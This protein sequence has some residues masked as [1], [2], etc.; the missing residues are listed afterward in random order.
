MISVVVLFYSNK[1]QSMLV[2]YVVIEMVCFD[3][4]SDAALSA[5]IMR[6]D[7]MNTSLLHVDQC[8]NF[9]EFFLLQQH[10]LPRHR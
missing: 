1:I 4:Y 2:D 9:N 3:K 10:L 6:G 8:I 7:G 5:K